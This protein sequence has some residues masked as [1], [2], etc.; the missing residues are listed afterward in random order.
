MPMLRRYLLLK[1][2][3]A[4]DFNDLGVDDLRFDDVELLSSLVEALTPIE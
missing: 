3:T 1:N 4:K 2:A